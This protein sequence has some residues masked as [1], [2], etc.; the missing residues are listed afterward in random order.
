MS[1]R[2]ARRE[3]LQDL[4]VSTALMP[5]LWNL[6]SLG[7]ANP[8]RRK[9][10][11]VIVFSPNG[12]VPP[13]FWPDEEGENF[14]LKPSLK[15]LEPFRDRTLILN[16]VCDKV[17]GDGDGH[18]RGIGCLLTG[19]ELF[20]GSVLGG[21]QEHPAGW[22]RGLSIDQALRGHLQSRDET[23]TRFG[24]LEFGVRVAERADTW[25][26]MVYSR[27]NQPVAP[28][29]DPYQMFQRMYGRRKH[30]QN[31]ASVLDGLEEE[32]RTVRASVSADDQRLLDEHAALVRQ[33]EKELSEARTAATAAPVPELEPGVRPS[34]ENMPRMSKMQIELLA[35]GFAADFT[36]IA[37]LQYNH[38][39]SDATMPWLKIS[40]RHHDIS[41][42]PDSD[43]AA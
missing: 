39:T 26:R 7:I 1:K 31:L 12:V 37:T 17:G 42:K 25:T 16:G 32:F 3:F 33:M 34:D 41:H 14:T 29:N 35:H 2:F 21:C 8:E 6:P 30:Q 40:E 5:F 38:S 13:T 24:S 18:M 4:G 10:R 11:L 36:R 9:Q 28:V 19:I 15:P 20:P 27:P 43:A 23:R 22:S